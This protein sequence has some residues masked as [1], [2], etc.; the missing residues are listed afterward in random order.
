M[1]SLDNSNKIPASKVKK[2]GLQLVKPGAEAPSAEPEQTEKPI[3]LDG[4]DHTLKAC[5]KWL[6][7]H[8]VK[9]CYCA[10]YP[11]GY[12]Y[13]RNNELTLDSEKLLWLFINRNQNFRLEIVRSCFAELAEEA[14]IYNPVIEALERLPELPDPN[15][16]YI[17]ELAGEIAEEGEEKGAAEAIFLWLKQ[18][19]AAAYNGI[20]NS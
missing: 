8:N 5:R 4:N 6:E 2:T 19:I 15:Y 11:V 14:P 12:G 1:D 20:D 3:K 10:Y 7:K 17:A 9:V 16:D 13:I 18:A